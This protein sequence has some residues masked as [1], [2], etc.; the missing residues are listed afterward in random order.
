MFDRLAINHALPDR[1]VMLFHKDYPKGQIFDGRDEAGMLERGWQDT[2]I[3][4]LS[5]ASLS[6]ASQPSA[7]ASPEE[8]INALKA[9]GFAVLTPVEVEAQVEAQKNLSPAF[10]PLPV[11]GR[12]LASETTQS[13]QVE[14]PPSDTEESALMNSFVDVHELLELY[15]LSP[16]GMTDAELIHLGN[17]LYKLGLRSNMK[18]ETLL[19][20]VAAE[21]AKEEG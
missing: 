19:E 20:K 17:G 10:N 6:S 5:G 14:T 18:R 4:E 2:P 16:D 12:I 9:M 8:M 1:K 7:Q 15:K 21:V 13:M 3:S 11:M